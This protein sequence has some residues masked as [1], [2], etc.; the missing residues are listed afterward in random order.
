MNNYDK[1]IAILRE[2]FQ[3][4][5][6][7]L[8]FGI[9]R[10]M[11]QKRDEINDFL[12]NKLIPQVK[13]E[14]AKANLG[15][16]SAIQKE[17][18][19]AIAGAKVLG[20]DPDGVQKIKDLKAQLETTKPVSLIE[21]EVFSHLAAFFKRYY[22]N[23]DF[24]SLRR[25]KKD[26]YAIP[27][28]GEEVKLY[29][30]NHDQYYIKSSEYLKNYQFKVGGNRRVRFELVEASTEQDNNKA[31][32]GK[33]RQFLIHE[34]KPLAEVDDSLVIYFTYLPSEKK[35]KREDLNAAAFEAIKPVLPSDWVADVLQKVP[36]NSNGDR[37]LLEKH[38]NDFT[39]R[40]TF[41]YFIHKDLGGF[42]RR[43]LDFYIKN[44]VLHIDDIN[45]EDSKDFTRQLTKI[46]ALKVIAQKVI[47]FLEQLENFQKRLWLK[48]KFV[49]ETNY[50]ITLDKIPNS[51]HEEII[52]NDDQWEEWE[53]LFAISEIPKDLF[54]E[55]AGAERLTL[56]NEQPYLVLDTKFFS[57]DFKFRLLAEYENLEEDIDG[58]LINSENFQA[59]NLAKEK[60][61]NRINCIYIDPPYNTGGDGFPYKDNY[62]HSSWLTMMV[63]RIIIS[64]Q[65]ISQ[66]GALFTSIN[67]IESSV[68]KSLL[69]KI[70]EPKNH[71]A[72]FVWRIEGN[73]DNQAKIKDAHE[74]VLAYAK[75]ESQFKSPPVIDPS[76]GDKSKLFKDEIRNTI[77]KNGPKNPESDIVIPVGFPAN[78]ANGTI[79]SDDR[80]Y[81]KFSDD[82]IIK[83][84]AV[85]NEVI[86]RSGWS[87][88]ILCEQFIKNNFHPVTDSKGQ[89]SVFELTHTGAIEVIKKRSENQ[90]YVT[91]VITSVGTTQ[92]TSA[93]LTKMGTPYPHY[94]KPVDLVKYLISM[95][96]KNTDYVLDYFSG[97]GTTGH[98]VIKLNKEDGG[99]RKYVLV[100]MGEYFNSVTKPRIQK[101]IY[102]EDWKNG[103]PIS[104]KGS[105][106]MFKYIRLES[107]ED[108]L[109]N[110]R[111]VRKEQQQNVLDLDSSFYEEYMLGYMLDTETKESLLSIKDF[112][113]PFNY[114]LTITENNEPKPTVVDMVE[115]FNYLIGIKVNSIKTI[116]GFR[117][118][119]GTKRTGEST[120]VVWR[121]VEEKNNDALLTFFEKYIAEG[122]F[123]PQHIYINGD[124]TVSNL[125]K[126]GDT[127][128]VYL[129]EKVFL[130]RMFDVQDV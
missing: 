6:A 98:S 25:Y 124:N 5:Q 32:N 129:T 87:S 14:I 118:V 51:Y 28:E 58:V 74:Y 109:N 80:K 113:N 45:T 93:M 83:D 34:E 101:I 123:A 46:K 60:Y 31:Q 71:L 2:V 41:D 79:K 99:N 8:D 47:A 10:I 7:D 15:D 125:Q 33:E 13:E 27:Y 20:V 88:N 54:N 26:V 106:H 91:S 17:L 59:L 64:K 49:V 30:A 94:P 115:T 53:K 116:D 111:V 39:A 40:N 104:R 75:N 16:A 86:A 48:K 102:S 65:M 84:Y 42:L 121:N 77:V 107:Y 128:K 97:S 110:L 36:T 52:A 70:F 112:A 3:I 43:E 61:I 4:D 67:D 92:S 120:L 130:Q 72:D 21:E 117:V 22:D 81:P 44:E 76:I 78:F 89:E 38:I 24:I 63:N 114:Q 126:E 11:N 105:S 9:Y 96:G 55:G 62:K 37:T 1:L 68:L 119:T 56:L 23:G 19:E 127:W 103:K 95:T 66:V 122:T 90:S 69:E 35:A 50:C 12:E 18:E 100:E 108:S 85:T 82:I 29:W 73:F 57:D